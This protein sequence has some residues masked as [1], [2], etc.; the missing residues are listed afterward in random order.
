MGTIIRTALTPTISHT[1]IVAIT[2]GLIIG[3]LATV[4]TATIITIIITTTIKLR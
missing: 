4:T 1:G 2:I 3:T